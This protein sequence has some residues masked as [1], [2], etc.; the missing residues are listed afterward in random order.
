MPRIVRHPEVRRAEL[1]AA[2]ARLFGARGYEAASVDDIIGDVGL[3]KGAF[4]YYFPS[5]DA[6]LEALARQAAERARAELEAILATPAMSAVEQLN[7]FLRR[8]RDTD[9]A[10]EAIA[11]FASIFLPENI[12]LYH[13]MHRA[14]MAVMAPALARIIEKGRREGSMASND[15][16]ISAE[17][18][19]LLGAV[20][21]GAVADLLA[22]EG[23]DALSQAIAAFERRLA[24]QGLAVDRILGL[25]DGTARFVEPGFVAAMAAARPNRNPLGATVAAG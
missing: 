23:A 1:L 13:R 11:T 22:A 14:V 12:V 8:G 25:P 2:A 20:T 9:R 17:L 10:A 24:E 15:P 3:S 7:A 18:V 21:H 5:K 16:L 6:L 4:Y 19:L